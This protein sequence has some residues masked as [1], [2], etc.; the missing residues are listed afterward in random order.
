M[1]SVDPDGALEPDPDV[2][3]VLEVALLHPA[4]TA[5]RRT[6]ATAVGRSTGAG[7]FIVPPRCR[8]EA[9]R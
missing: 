7:S 4:M 1:V 6:A 9:V 2:D 8:S 5:A 3:P